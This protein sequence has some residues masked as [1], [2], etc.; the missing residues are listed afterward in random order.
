MTAKT[1]TNITIAMVSEWAAIHYTWE[2]TNS[3]P[4]ASDWQTRWTVASNRLSDV[5]LDDTLTPQT[6]EPA[7]RATQR[8]HST[9]KHTIWY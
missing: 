3:D 7:K 1:D 6:I 8:H 9:A 2:C 4:K 5:T